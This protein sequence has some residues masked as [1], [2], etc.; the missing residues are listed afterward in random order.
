MKDFFGIQESNQMND[1]PYLL[2]MTYY[3]I[4]SL[5]DGLR[6]NILFVLVIYIDIKSML[7]IDI[8]SIIMLDPSSNDHYLEIAPP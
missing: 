8:K 2:P 4:I 3:F 1:N 5:L 7:V 6:E